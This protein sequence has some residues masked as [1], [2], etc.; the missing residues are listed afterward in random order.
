MNKDARRNPLSGIRAQLLA[1]SIL[2]L[3]IASVVSI[4]AAIASMKS[5]L[6]EEALDQLKSVCVAVKASFDTMNADD[7]AL[8]EAGEL[9]KGDFNITAN[10]AELDQHV[11]GTDTDVTLFYGD[12]RKATT[13]IDAVSGERII[14]TTASEAVAKAVLGGEEYSA[15]SL[16]INNE[17]YYAYYIPLKNPD[18]TII[19]MVF[20][21]APSATIDRF[22]SFRCLFLIGVVVVVAVIAFIVIMILSGRLVKA[23]N[24]AKEAIDSLA[25]GDLTYTIDDSVL[26]RKDE[27]GDMVRGAKECI[28]H[29]NSTIGDI[30]N[31]AKDVLTNGE[32][33][34]NMALETSETSTNISSTVDDLSTGAV[35]LAEDIESATLRIDEMGQLIESIVSNIESLNSTSADM[36]DASAKAMDIM[37]ELDVSNNKTREAV[38]NVAEN[39]AETDESVNRIQDAVTMIMSVAA[40][41]NLLC[42]SCFGNTEAVGR[43][44]QL[45]A[46]YIGDNNKAF[47][48]VS[49]FS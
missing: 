8:N 41:T 10:T 47:G 11:E 19:G 42:R 23:V 4:W 16:T 12:T 45:G 32:A 17:N 44:K 39:V 40:Q 35:S 49:Q 30:Q 22:I 5:G 18:G 48:G 36:R 21:G 9:I 38:L 25:A 3:L 37:H 31:Y 13:L 14:G 27:I 34:E 46:A 1:M 24:N 7:Y 43:G 29:L 20:A 15:L 33:L 28:D 2:P 6:Q 26:Q